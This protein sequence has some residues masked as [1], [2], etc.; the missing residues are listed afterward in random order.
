MEQYPAIRGKLGTTEFYIIVIKAKKLAEV[1]KIQ[2]PED[3]EKSLA[4]KLS[5]DEI[6][7][8]KLDYTRVEKYIAPYIAEDDDRFFGSVIIAATGEWDFSSFEEILAGNKVSPLFKPFLSQLNAMGVLTMS[9]GSVWRPLDGQHRI[10]AIRCAIE[11]KNNKGVPLTHFLTSASLPDE[12]VSVI[13]IPYNLDKTRKIFTKVNLYAKKISPGEGLLIDPYDIVAVL[14]R[15]MI[16]KFG[17]ARLVGTRKAEIKPTDTIFTTLNALNKANHNIIK[18]HIGDKVKGEALPSKEKQRLY[19]T[20]L[21]KVWDHLLKNINIF[22]DALADKSEAGDKKRKEL[23]QNFLLLQPL[24]Q[25]CLATAF[26]RLTSS[27]KDLSFDEASDRLNKINWLKTDKAWRFVLIN[28]AGGMIHRHD[29]LVS[30]LIYYM[31]G[32]N[33]KPKE[34]ETLLEK[35]RRLSPLEKAEQDKIKLPKKVV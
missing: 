6:E 16:D 4:G 35:Y 9:D 15:G 30:D 31:A 13:L 8:R 2:S 25:S 27:K 3:W 17:G 26:A 28:S 19:A 34:E 22:T 14:S 20:Q 11:R 23:R 18:W 1:T 12:D 32:G 29:K 24:P 21:N 33:M 10:A 5:D 7:Q